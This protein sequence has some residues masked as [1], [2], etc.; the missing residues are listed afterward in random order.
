MTL[1]ITI[2]LLAFTLGNGLLIFSLWNLHQTLLIYRNGLETEATIVENTP[3]QNG[4]LYRSSLHYEVN[5]N[6]YQKIFYSEKE[7]ETFKTQEKIKII[8]QNNDPTEI[9]FQSYYQ[10]LTPSIIGLCLAL[11]MVIY[12]GYYLLFGNF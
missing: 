11:P 6:V 3:I 10:M 9:H 7:A 1:F 4:D 8:Y 2:L 5:G 12:A